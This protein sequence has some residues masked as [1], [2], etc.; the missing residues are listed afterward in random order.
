[1]TIKAIPTEYNGTKYRSRT[2]ARWAVFF[3]QCGISVRYEAEGYQTDKGWY[4]PDF[5]FVGVPRK[6][7]FEVKPTAPN[8]QEF[9]LLCA[10]AAGAGAH[11]FCSISPPDVGAVI[12]KA[13]SDGHREQWHFAKDSAG[14]VSFLSDVLRTVGAPI[15]A[16]TLT[17][18]EFGAGRELLAASQYRFPLFDEGP[19]KG[20]VD[21]RDWRQ[22]TRQMLRSKG[23]DMTERR[24]RR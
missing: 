20:G 8:F 13:F 4:L 17:M 6:T 16:G 10:L 7:F 23:A 2:E 11:V 24:T 22:Q 19:A 3:D 9:A 5:E 21:R 15:R 1:M 14:R 18:T 12:W